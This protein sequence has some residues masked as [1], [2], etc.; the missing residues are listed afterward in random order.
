[1]AKDSYD[2]YGRESWDSAVEHNGR[3]IEKVG[4]VIKSNG[5]EDTSDGIVILDSDATVAIS[6]AIRIS[7][8]YIY[9]IIGIDKPRKANGDIAFQRFYVKREA[10]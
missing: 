10:V 4:K 7:G 9:R 6:S 2:Q 8:L 3:F 5:E 1:M